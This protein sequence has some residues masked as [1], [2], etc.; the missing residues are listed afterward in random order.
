MSLTK[1]IGLFLSKLG[2]SWQDRINNLLFRLNLAL[3]IFQYLILALKFSQLPDQLPLYYSLSWGESQLTT[4]SQLFLLPII[5]TIVFITNHFF[6]SFLFSQDRLLSRL[7]IIFSLIVSVFI[8]YSL[9]KII[10]LVS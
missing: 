1:K 5:S 3:V 9:T 2:S 8:G 4:S 10:F 6:A 7:L